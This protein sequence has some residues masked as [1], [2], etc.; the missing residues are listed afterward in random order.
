MA[1]SG[2]ASISRPPRP[3]LPASSAPRGVSSTKVAVGSVPS[4]TSI[5][6]SKIAGL[7][8]PI[9]PARAAREA[10]RRAR[11]AA[12]RRTARAA[13][14]AARAAPRTAKAER[15]AR[16]VIPRRTSRS[17]PVSIRSKTATATPRRRRPKG[18]LRAKIRQ[19]RRRP[20]PGAKQAPRRAAAATDASASKTTRARAKAP[21]PSARV[22]PRSVRRG[23]SDSASWPRSVPRSPAENG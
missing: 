12:A 14:R 2:S 13:P 11:E 20:V 16:T 9:L 6:T 22:R 5:S 18:P 3:A 7:R 1:A 21:A 23:S 15:E 8:P 4:S 17:I 10:P 19:S